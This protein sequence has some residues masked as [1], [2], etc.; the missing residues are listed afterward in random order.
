MRARERLPCMVRRGRIGTCGRDLCGARGGHAGDLPGNG[1]PLGR[2]LVPL[3]F[4][5]QVLLYLL[6]R[7]RFDLVHVHTLTDALYAA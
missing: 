3:S 1:T 2:R 6:R 7:P 4:A 5:M